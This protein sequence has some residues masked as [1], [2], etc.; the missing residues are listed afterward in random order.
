MKAVMEAGFAQLLFNV[1]GAG[2][3]VFSGTGK[4]SLITV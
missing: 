3:A 4:E 2:M 1:N